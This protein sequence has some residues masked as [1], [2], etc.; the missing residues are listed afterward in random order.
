ME[1]LNLI[2]R[3]LDGGGFPSNQLGTDKSA[4]CTHIQYA[5]Q[6][7]AFF[8]IHNGQCFRL[9]ILHLLQGFGQFHSSG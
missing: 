7:P 8:T 2:P 5:N 3:P 4:C 9:I 6:L 1:W